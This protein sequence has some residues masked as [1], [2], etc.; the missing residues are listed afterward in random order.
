MTQFA[1]VAAK[2]TLYGISVFLLIVLVMSTFKIIDAGEQGV[3]TRLGKV[4]EE[5]L[6]PGVHIVIPVVDRLY[7]FSTRIRKMEAS[8]DS[9]SKDLQSVTTK[10]ALNF[11]LDSKN[12][13]KLY[14]EVGVDWQARI[15][16]PAIQESVKSATAQ[17][18]AEE[19]ITKRSEM[20][21]AVAD[22]LRTRL[23]SKYITVDDVSIT[24]FRFSGEFEKA[25]EAKQVAEQSALKARQDL[26]RIKIEA[27]QRVTTARAEADSLRLQR[28]VLS[29]DLL[30]LRAIEKWDGKLPQATSG[31]PFISLTPRP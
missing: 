21:A 28:E 13:N 18:T 25:V 11:Q 9:A 31:N 1:T 26:E 15:V 24:D 20:K 30:Q 19:L 16:D 23:S 17:F 7:I 14:Q 10:I 3:V 2:K 8:S 27:E 5:T 6:A 12:I 22:L 29:P 4:Q